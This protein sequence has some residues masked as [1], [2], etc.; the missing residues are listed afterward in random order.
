MD[1]ID[2]RSEKLR[3]SEDEI[4][5]LKDEIRDIRKKQQEKLEKVAKLTKEDA[6]EKLMKMTERDIRGDM[7]GLVAKDSG[8]SQGKRRRKSSASNNPSH[9]AHGQR[10]NVRA[11]C[12]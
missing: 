5:S 12:H 6:A 8:R 9:G 7:I 11:N 1:E 2:K 10:C 3:K 4:E